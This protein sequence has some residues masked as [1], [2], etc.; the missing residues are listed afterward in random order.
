MKKLTLCILSTFLM[1]LVIP[2]QLKAN[3]ENNA[4]KM[5]L[6]SEIKTSDS[7][8]GANQLSMIKAKEIATLSSSENK[9]VLKEESPLKNNQDRRSRGYQNRH[10]R[11]DVNVTI[12]PG[13]Q[14]RGD[15]YNEGRHNHGGAYLGVGGVL[16][17]ILILVLVL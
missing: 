4:S 11:R 6:R 10:A 17:L 2:N 3:T 16:I 13:H 9:E 15:G 8:M 1:F 5:T 7:N 14:M 12:T